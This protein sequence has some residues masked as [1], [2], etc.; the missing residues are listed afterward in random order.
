M[1]EFPDVVQYPDKRVVRYQVEPGAFAVEFSPRPHDECQAVPDRRPLPY[2]RQVRRPAHVGH[3]NDRVP[4][5]PLRVS[6][7]PIPPRRGVPEDF[8]GGALRGR[9]GRAYPQLDGQALLERAEWLFSRL[10]LRRPVRVGDQGAQRAADLG[11]GQG[12]V[13]LAAGDGD[14]LFCFGDPGCGSPA[15]VVQ[16][17]AGVTC[18]FFGML[19]GGGLSFHRGDGLGCCGA[20][21]SSVQLGGVPGDRLAGGLGAGLPD[22]GGGL[23]AD[24][25]SLRFGGLGV[26]GRGQLAAEG[27]EL[28]QDGWQLRAQPAH[29][30]ERVV[31]DGPGPADGRGDRPVPPPPLSP[32]SSPVPSPRSSGTSCS[33]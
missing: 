8:L 27:S 22:L 4:G 11:C 33:Q 1:L 9:R 31:A 7:T 32:L 10:H 21:L 24:G 3:I 17:A 15:F 26:A 12:G 19:A 2:R 23:G 20:G 16:R 25:L 6:A 13:T 18:E 14:G 5:A 29:R 30:G 28:V